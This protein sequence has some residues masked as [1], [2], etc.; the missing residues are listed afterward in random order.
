MKSLKYQGFIK[1]GFIKSHLSASSL[2]YNNF[3]N[4]Q[5]SQERVSQSRRLCFANA[6]ENL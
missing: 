5:F 4:L 3:L 1:R 6:T 2:K